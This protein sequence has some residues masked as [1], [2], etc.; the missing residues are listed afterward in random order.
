MG[1][2]NIIVQVPGRLKE[3]AA[4]VRDLVDS[5]VATCQPLEQ[6]A[7]YVLADCCTGALF[8]ECHIKA[9]VLVKH[10]TVDV[11]LDP[12]EQPEYRANR[13][14]VEDHT[15]YERM[16]ADALSGRPFSNLVIEYRLPK[17]DETTL[18]IIG[19]Q[20]RFHAIQNAHEKGVNEYQGVKV[21]FG[22]DTAQRLDVQ[23]V[24]NT[25]IA[26]SSD[27]LDRMY[28]TWAGPELRT[29]CQAVGLLY[30]G[31]DFADK[32]QRGQ[33]I[34]VRAARTFIMNYLSG[35]EVDTTKF[36][37]TITTPII[38]KTGAD[39][40]EWKAVK[41]KY[42]KMWDDDGMKD[43][44][45]EF[46]ALAKAQRDSFTDPRTERRTNVDFAE[47]ASNYAILSAWAY[48][49]GILSRNAPRLKRHFALREAKGKDPLQ[50]AALARG[51][52]KTDAENYRGLGYR[53]D[54]KERG[55]LAELFFLQAEKG[56]GI[57]K[58][59]IDLAIKKYHAKQAMSEVWEAE[60]KG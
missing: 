28:E 45:R 25:N 47:K 53:T 17:D 42:P 59:L 19:G 4:K 44:G 56:E 13:E 15:A 38:A 58:A 34:T 5:F 1:E 18:M 37:Q 54:A 57:T 27:L 6:G 24:S 14:L 55:R 23:L 60:G 3:K 39:D 35:K 40:P 52:H 16:K 21:H 22:L 50:A 30:E 20:H 10:G 51:R 9:S 12:E 36:D 43:A 29:W 48:T 32:R 46:A 33:P 26:V 31:Q 2:A 8:C 11:P 49:A 7:L 41:E